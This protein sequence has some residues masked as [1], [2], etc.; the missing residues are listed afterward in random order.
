M[1]LFKRL[2]ALLSAAA[3]A[4][5]AVPAMP[6]VEAD[7]AT[8]ATP[9][10]TAQQILD[11]MGIGWNLGNSLDTNGTGEW[12]EKYWGN[13]E[14]TP[15]LIKFVHSQGFSSIRIPVTWGYH[16]DADHKIDASYM[17]RVKQVVDYAYND[18]MY[19]IINIHHDNTK[20]GDTNYFYPDSEH[21]AQSETF[22]KSVWEQISETF[23]DYDQHLVF[24]TLNEP[25]LIDSGY[26]WWFDVNNVPYEVADAVSVINTLNQDAVDTIRAS[27]GNNKTRLIMCPGYDASFDGATVAGFKLPTDSSNMT[28]VSIHAYSPYD[29]AMNVYNQ[30]ATSV[31][32]DSIKS[33]LEGFFK[34]VKTKIIDKGMFC[35]IG[36][37][38]ATNK[39]NNAER[40]KW[41]EDYTSQ[42][43]ALGIPV[44]LWDNNVYGSGEELFGM[45]KRNE[46][47]IAYPD[48]LKALTKAYPQTEA[49]R[50][51]GDANKDKTLS[52]KD[53][54]MIQQYLA[55]WNVDI[56]LKNA[57]VDGDNDVT[58]RD[59][60]LIKQKLAY[61]NVTLI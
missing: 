59:I 43:K 26:Q 10:M 4:A 37:F 8:A 23:K 57:D 61:W 33:Q 9:Q 5:A 29:F 15:E 54:T 44:Y 28:G 39:D 12:S 6:A 40:C 32:S 21:K 22:V 1:K 16:M 34:E 48:Y 24:E 17:K 52:V 27:G 42:A 56:D 11:E 2:T 41:A 13:P 38:G 50:V 7:A 3:I 53:V 51:P 25:R 55:N 31:Y 19:V 20:K 18:G 35:Y 30:G 49:E 58:V 47:S 60:T 46:L 36:E 14:I 45:V